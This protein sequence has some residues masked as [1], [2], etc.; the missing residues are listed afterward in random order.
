LDRVTKE[1]RSEIMSKVRGKNTSPELV[2]RKL[3]FSLGYRYR[4]HGKHLPGTPDL[5]FPGRKK[6]I[7]VHGCFWHYHNC[8][9]GHPPKSRLEYW[10]PKLEANKKRD[11]QKSQE[12]INQGWKI[13]VV[14]QC[15]IKNIPEL[16]QT[17]VKFLD[18]DKD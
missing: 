17:I 4:L 11:S 5:V 7:F 13:L 3:V 15:E 10:L 16:E 2:V 9:I 14:W 18:F 6:V 12:L 8:K 1:K